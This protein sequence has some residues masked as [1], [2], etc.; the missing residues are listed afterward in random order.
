MLV[1]RALKAEGVLQE[2]W[3]F[4]RRSFHGSIFAIFAARGGLESDVFPRQKKAGSPPAQDIKHI[5]QTL[6]LVA[7]IRAF[8]S[9]GH[10]AATLG[11]RKYSCSTCK[12]RR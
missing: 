7:L 5:S 6:K 4:Q 11:K 1:L 9:R 2:P 8:R 10:F 3:N 12:N